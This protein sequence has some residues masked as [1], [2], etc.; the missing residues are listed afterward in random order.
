MVYVGVDL[1]GTNIAVGLVDAEGK[2][3]HKDSVP[4]LLERGP[5]P[6]IRDM[7]NLSLKVIKD[8]GYA[9]DDVKAIGVGVPGLADPKTGVVIFCTNLRWHMVPLRE[10]MQSIIEKPVFIDSDATVAGLAESVAGVSA[11]V[12]NSV[13]LTLGTGVGGGIVIN[14]KIYS[15]S[16]GVG[17]ELGHMTVQCEGRPC[18]CGSV[19]CWEQ[20]SSATALIRQGREAVEGHPESLIV[21][22]VDGDLSKI[23]ARTV[24]D[25]A[26]QGD[27]IACE[28]YDKYIYYLAIGIVAIINA[29]DPEII[30]L[31]GGVSKAGDFLLEPL[32]KKVAQYVFY[33][34][35]PYADIKIATLGNDAGIIGAAM[36]GK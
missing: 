14:H 8:A 12:A 13:F 36:L 33:K 32:K 3:L 23:E 34:D 26:R 31:G 28:V 4:T 16:H 11:G 35:L 10:I 5:E 21:K 1:G 22:M 2:I 9:L 6:V 17:S 18:T 24:I 15:G 19:G 30:A 29:F 20:Y 7:A 25:A 27:P